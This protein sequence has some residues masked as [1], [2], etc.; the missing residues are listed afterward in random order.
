MT[1]ASFS[2]DNMQENPEGELR[3]AKTIIKDLNIEIKKGEFVAV[4]G[5]VGA[6]KSSIFQA[7]IQNMNLVRTSDQTQVFINGTVSYV[8][9]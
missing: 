9:Q 5:R 7:L 6:G 2:W 4:V 1:D 3:E 8:S